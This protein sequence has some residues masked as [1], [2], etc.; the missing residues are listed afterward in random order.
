MLDRI[1]A[2]LVSAKR[3]FGDEAKITLIMLH[4]EYLFIIFF[5]YIFRP[6]M[7]GL[8]NHGHYVNMYLFIYFSAEAL[9]SIVA[10]LFHHVMVRKTDRC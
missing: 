8:E 5:L 9:S 2:T 10:T 4:L 6:L 7:K 1:W 3:T